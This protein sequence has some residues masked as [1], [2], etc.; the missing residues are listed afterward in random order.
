MGR[1][2]GRLQDR[3][4]QQE[5][6]LHH[7]PG[8]AGHPPGKPQMMS[9]AS[10]MPGTLASSTSATCLNSATLYSR[11]MAD[12]TASLPLCRR[13]GRGAAGGVRRVMLTGC[14]GC[15]WSDG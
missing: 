9:V 12:R 14:A 1:R 4:G 10:S 11:F 2:V 13:A 5:V 3:P 7:A 8:T 6:L 15:S